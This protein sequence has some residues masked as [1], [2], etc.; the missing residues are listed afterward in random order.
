MIFEG[1]SRVF[2]GNFNKTFKVF[3]GKLHVAWHSSQLP[4]QKEGLFGQQ[5]CLDQIPNLL[6]PDIILLNSKINA[7]NKTTATLM[8]FDTIEAKWCRTV[9]VFSS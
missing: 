9:A 4:E 6:Q 8:G 1:I 7:I 3:Q 2:Q 5:F